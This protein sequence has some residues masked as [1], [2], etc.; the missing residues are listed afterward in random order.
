MSS[1]TLPLK[2]LSNNTMSC[3]EIPHISS[4]QGTTC[5]WSDPHGPQLIHHTNKEY[6]HKSKSRKWGREG[7]RRSWRGRRRREEKVEGGI[8]ATAY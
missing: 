6:I 2:T 7:R 3:N 8:P 1:E 5:S 4:V